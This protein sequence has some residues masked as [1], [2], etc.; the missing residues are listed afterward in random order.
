[1]DGDA[2]L[3]LATDAVPVGL[4]DL[5]ERHDRSLLVIGRATTTRTDRRRTVRQFGRWLGRHVFS[6]TGDDVLTW[7]AEP[8]WS[9][10]TRQTYLGHI[11]GFY[12]WAVTGQLIAADPTSVVG[13]IRVPM[14]LPKPFT[15]SQLQRA[16]AALPQPV[17]AW[18]VLA[19]YAG[20]RCCEIASLRGEDI[21]HDART[22][23]VRAGKGAVQALLPAHD[24]V[25]AEVAE[26]PRGGVL[27]RSRGGEPLTA[28]QVSHKGHETLRRIGVGGS[29]HRARH[30]F[31]TTIYRSTGGDI[32]VTQELL[33]HR[34]PAT[35]ARYTLI[36]VDEKRSALAGLP[37]FDE[38]P[39]L[40]E[41]S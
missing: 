7:L 3:T 21:D 11:R 8:G 34:S 33:R 14:P 39:P 16:L 25:M 27:W 38:R 30:S 9:A 29:M 2:L 37:R 20:L 12:Q 18:F 40:D 19:A 26:M 35:T 6:A 13:P 22:L 15:D 41:A 5:L 4:D 23:F 24:L 31:G 1:M 28:R 36:T 17:H 32:R 10:Q